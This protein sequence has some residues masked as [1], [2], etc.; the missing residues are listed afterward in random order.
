VRRD[1]AA[2]R[3]LFRRAAAAGHAGG[4]RI[5]MA[6]A[7]GGI[8]GPV[9]WPRAVRLLQQLAPHDPD[10]ARQLAL[11]ARMSVSPSGEPLA[12]PPPERLSDQ[13]SAVAFR[14]LL[15]PDECDHLVALAEPRLSPAVVIDPR[16]GRQVRNPVRTSDSMALPYVAET[17]LT[18]AL[19]RR[20]AAVSG[21]QAPQG[22]PL[23]VLRYRGGQE[24]R[25]HSDALAGE[26]NQRVLTLLVYLNEGYEGGDT[27]FV[28]TGLRFRGR[29]GDALL[30][31]N[32]LPDGRADP[33]AQHAGLPVTRGEKL[34]ATRWIRERPFVLPPPRPVLDV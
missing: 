26:P 10:A 7:A 3:D 11:L 8:G 2:S 19:T 6:F 29:K 21:T 31:R 28:N 13:P 14:S 12:L 33:R 25:P 5:Y 20:M 18:H 32:T 22:E 24:Y 9:D 1:L 23:Q 34:L 17:P 4:L 15:T 27:L 16:S 30:F